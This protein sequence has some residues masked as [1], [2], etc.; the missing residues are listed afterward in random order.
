MRVF[1]FNSEKNRDRSDYYLKMILFG[2]VAS[3]LAI[4]FGNTLIGL[5]KFSASHWAWTVGIILAAI[6][7]KKYL[8]YK[9]EERM[10]RR[11]Y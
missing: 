3:V 9:K 10:R 8:Q 11:G 4:V 6:F 5:L 1:G 7:T 2:G